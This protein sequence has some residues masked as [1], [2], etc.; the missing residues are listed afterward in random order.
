MQKFRNS[1]TIVSASPCFGHPW[2]HSKAPLSRASIQT[3]VACSYAINIW[4]W[5]GGW[6]HYRRATR[7]GSGTVSGIRSGANLNLLVV[8]EMAP[9]A[10]A[11]DI[12]RKSN[13]MRSDWFGTAMS[14]SGFMHSLL[15]TAALHQYIVG[16]ASIETVIHHR[17]QAITAINSALK[18]PDPSIGISDANIGAVF[19]LFCV[20]ESLLFPWIQQERS[21]DDEPNQRQIH[22]DGLR[23]MVHLRGGLMAM[24]SNRILQ[25]FI[26]W[27][28]TPAVYSQHAETGFAVAY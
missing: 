10:I 4:A 12:R 20:E 16:R 1:W 24:S 21:D 8:S 9:V 14:N 7:S 27:C 18:D 26:L 3:L 28:V 22:L 2:L 25:A 6:G 17:A 23:R 5:K 19:N 15:C 11:V 13:R